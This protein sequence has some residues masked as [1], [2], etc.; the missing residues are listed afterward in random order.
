M[1]K[2]TKIFSHTRKKDETKA[3]WARKYYDQT[4]PRIRSVWLTR[5][6]SFA[7][8]HRI[9]CDHFFKVC[10]TPARHGLA[11]APGTS[12]HDEHIRMRATY[13]E[14]STMQVSSSRKSSGASCDIRDYEG[15]REERG[16]ELGE[17]EREAGPLREG[18][19]KE[20]N[21]RDQACKVR[22]ETR[23]RFNITVF[24]SLSLLA[25]LLL[26]GTC[27]LIVSDLT[28]DAS[29]QPLLLGRSRR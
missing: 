1:K 14:N 27:N 12:V 29:K 8:R 15:A 18:G 4:K 23:C 25:Y 10:V 11:I 3:D 22:R 16:E 19:R 7:I 26:L 17:C 6:T 2:S 28:F 9:M 21:G 5:R 13:V 24:L 20:E